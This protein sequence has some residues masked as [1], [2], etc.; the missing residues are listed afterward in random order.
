VATGTLRKINYP[1]PVSFDLAGVHSIV[2]WCRAFGVTVTYAD[3][4]RP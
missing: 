1:L 2:V 3:L 4:A